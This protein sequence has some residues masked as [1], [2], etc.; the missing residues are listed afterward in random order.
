MKSDRDDTLQE[1]VADLEEIQTSVE[2][3]RLD[4]PDAVDDE[5]LEQL[6]TVLEQAVDVADQIEEQEET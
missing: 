3:L 6:E 4:P 5:A 2:E 1:I